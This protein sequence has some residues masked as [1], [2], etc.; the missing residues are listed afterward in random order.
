M[1]EEETKG[2][3]SKNNLAKTENNPSR[4]AIYVV[5]DK[6]GIVDDYILF[7]LKELKK[8]VSRLVVTVNGTLSSY[9]R[10]KLS[11]I[12]DDIFVRKNIGFDVGAW[13]ETM[14]EFL[15]WDVLYSYDELALINDTFYGPIYPLNDVFTEMEEKHVDFWGLSSHAESSAHWD[16]CPYD[17]QPE[18]IQSYFTVIGKILLCSREFRMYWEKQPFFEKGTDAIAQHEVVFTKYFHDMGYTW[19]VLSDMSDFDGT[20]PDNDAPACHCFHNILNM[21]NMRKYPVVKRH[22]FGFDYKNHIGCS[23][24]M[25]LRQTI[26]YVENHTNY[27]VSM[28]YK[29]ITRIYN[30]YDI[31]QNLHIIFALP[32]SCVLP[33]KG[34][35]GK[36]V[37]VYH[38]F[39]MD[40]FDFIK[41]YILSIPN[42]IDVLI[43]TSSAANKAY[44]YEC[45]KSSLG[46]RLH[47]VITENRGR[48]IS[49]L[50]V[51][52]APYIKE[53]DY[54]GFSHDKRE[55]KGQPVTIGDGFRELITENIIGGS[56]Y[57]LNVLATLDSHP[58]LGVLCPPPPNHASCAEALGKNAWTSCYKK[59][60]ELVKKLGLKVNLSEDK[61]PLSIGTAFWCRRDALAPLFDYPWE[62]SDFP[63]EPLP[64]DGTLNHALER[65]LPF[66]AQHQGYLT[67]WILTDEYA[68]LEINNIHYLLGF[69]TEQVNALSNIITTAT[70]N[71]K[72]LQ[73]TLNE[74]LSNNE[75]LSKLNIGL[76]GLLVIYFKKHTPKPLWGIAK[77]VKRLLGW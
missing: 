16:G 26:D 13:K 48:D 17:N 72:Q 57:I 66:V 51:A 32:K 53:Y 60:E 62:Y 71:D 41:P 55:H 31:F 30:V 44:I 45:L 14:I 46:E 7:F 49:A 76:K 73:A 56:A 20:Y 43:T 23:N 34:P 15:G 28:I 50:L 61:P 2:M 9:G 54:I 8:N 27:D 19:A 64:L 42:N 77:R 74:A 70:P 21:I 6:D 24:G 67:G 22:C 18:H 3:A 38:A 10:E 11:K 5:Y 4:I 47:V 39:Y 63:K 75:I 33:M 35:T 37:F 69:R 59:T 68:A 58:E 36:A 25:Q 1:V 29:N 40:L 52:A 65:I 12:A